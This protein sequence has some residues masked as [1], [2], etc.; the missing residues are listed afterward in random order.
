M[1]LCF[2]SEPNKWKMMILEFQELRKKLIVGA[3]VL[4]FVSGNMDNIKYN[5][6]S[7]VQSL[8]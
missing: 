8:V 1:F 3:C 6:P 2:L 5:M 7:L 4:F